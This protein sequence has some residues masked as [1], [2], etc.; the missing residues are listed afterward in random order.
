MF[1][2]VC[3][4]DRIRLDLLAGVSAERIIE[5]WQ[6]GLRAFLELREEYLIYE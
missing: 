2:K 6:P 4:S 3:G 5:K 1:D